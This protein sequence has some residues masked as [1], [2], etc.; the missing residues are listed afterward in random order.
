MLWSLKRFESPS[1]PLNVWDV[2]A[3]LL[4]FKRTAPKVVEQ[5]LVEWLSTAYL[6]LYANLAI[7]NI[8]SH[9]SRSFSKFTSRQL[10]LLNVICRRVALSEMKP[11][12]IRHGVQKQG[13]LQGNADEEIET[14][15]VL[16]LGSEMELRQRLVD[17]CLS[18]FSSVGCRPEENLRQSGLWSPTSFAQMKKWVA[19]KAL[20]DNQLKDLSAG[21][22][23]YKRRYQVK[24]HK[25]WSAFNWVDFH[26]LTSDQLANRLSVKNTGSRMAE[27]WMR[28]AA[29][30]RLQSCSSLPKLPS[31]RVRI[32]PVQ[33][34]RHTNL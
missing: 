16:V 4:V 34:H 30:A 13:M 6:G 17:Y 12:Q 21:I 29:F 7:K 10:Q 18:T 14:W 24:I 15:V 1:R 28:N 19:C 8:L 20:A 9:M 33:I 5:F 26:R 11:D 23:T 22:R 25:I 32:S 3:A 31:A 27:M 2:I